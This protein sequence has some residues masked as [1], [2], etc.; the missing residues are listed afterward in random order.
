MSALTPQ[1]LRDIIADLQGRHYRLCREGMLP[2]QVTTP[3]EVEMRVWQRALALVLSDVLVAQGFWTTSADVGEVPPL[4]VPLAPVQPC[5]EHGI[6]SG[7]LCSTCQMV[8]PYG[9]ARPRLPS[10]TCALCLKPK[11][12][13]PSRSAGHPL[14]S[15]RYCS[16][17]LQ[18]MQRVVSELYALAG[19]DAK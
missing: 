16:S 10:P 18:G 1:Q 12:P 13:D 8:V 2:G 7:Q 3:L 15:G 4:G 17:C 14:L 6:P 11:L 9:F 5:C 19:E